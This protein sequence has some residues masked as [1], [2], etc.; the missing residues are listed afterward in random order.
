[1]TVLLIAMH[2]FLFQ[3]Y[4]LFSLTEVLDWYSI[5][6]LHAA[7]TLICFT[8]SSTRSSGLLRGGPVGTQVGSTLPYQ[9]LVWTCS[10]SLLPSL[11][12]LLFDVIKGTLST[13]KGYVFSH[14]GV[15]SKASSCLHNP[16]ETYYTLH[17][18]LHSTCSL[19][20]DLNRN[21]VLWNKCFK[22]EN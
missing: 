12:L 1:M 17:D 16:G 5:P 6:S 2:Q 9:S 18:W 13:K 14:S 15:L 7:K 8:D 3:D 19:S 4:E 21:P 20:W 10:P 22:G 11:L